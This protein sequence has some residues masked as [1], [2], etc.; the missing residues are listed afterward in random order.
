MAKRNKLNSMRLLD[1]RSIPYEVHHYDKSIRDARQV[2]DA[3]GFEA[4]EVFKT[5]V[6]EAAK[7][8]KPVLVMLP[9]NTTLNLKRL[10]KALGEKKM[11][12]AS[13][14]DAEKLTGLQT[15]GISALAL[16]GKR[17]PVYLDKRAVARERILISAGKRGFQLRLET[18]ALIELLAC[19]VIDAA[20]A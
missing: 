19:E 3:V 18:A 1:A 5:L 8:K 2:A 9:S 16:M 12:L 14:A 20:D 15:G 7:A 11:A 4:G 10:A 17:W 6:A 13:H